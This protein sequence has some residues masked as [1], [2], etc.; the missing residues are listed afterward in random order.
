MMKKLLLISAL[1]S[2]C[3]TGIDNRGY[4]FEISDT[5][6]VQVGQ[7]KEEVLQALGSP[8]S[9]STFKDNSWYYVSRKIASK[10]FFKPDVIDHKVLVIHFDA[11]DRVSKIEEV[12]KDQVVKVEPNKEKTE[13]SGYETG[14]MREVFGNFGKFNGPGKAPTKS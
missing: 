4:D 5:S 3:T 2:A 13:T 9:T 8:S 7:S 6:K 10:S 14:I 11:G 1:L 12:S